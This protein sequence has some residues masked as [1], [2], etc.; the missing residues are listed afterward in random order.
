MNSSGVRQ[1]RPGDVVCEDCFREERVPQDHLSKTY[2][3]WVLDRAITPRISQEL[4]K[5]STVS[6]W[7]PDGGVSALYPVD[8]EAKHRQSTEGYSKCPLF[9]LPGL[10]AEAKCVDLKVPLES[11]K[12]KE[13]SGT[14]LF[15]QSDAHIREPVYAIGA[16]LDEVLDANVPLPLRGYMGKFPFG[17]THI[18]LMI[19]PLIIENGVT[20]YVHSL[21]I[22]A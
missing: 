19:G 21:E 13:K 9:L 6:R 18:S 11:R 7:D 10:V 14:Q 4:C 15:K 22:P 3:H 12:W 16:G 20:Q 8:P 17:N 5:C 1:L 2:K